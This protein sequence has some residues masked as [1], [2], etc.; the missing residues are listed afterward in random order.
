MANLDGN[1]S[2]G[3]SE[4]DD[5]EF[6]SEIDVPGTSLNDQEVSSLKTFEL[7]CWLQCRR[8]PTAGKKADLVA[9]LT[10]YPLC[11]ND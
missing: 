3:D 6:L 1:Y 10:V 11:E 7:K 8:A 2:S 5:E 9:R 4:S